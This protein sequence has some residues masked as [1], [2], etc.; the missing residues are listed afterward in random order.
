M[1]YPHIVRFFDDNN[2]WI[3]LALSEDMVFQYTC[4]FF[5]ARE[6]MFGFSINELLAASISNSRVVKRQAYMGVLMCNKTI[7]M[8]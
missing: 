2:D 6:Y 8:R 1:H 5:L 4:A 7:H 3:K